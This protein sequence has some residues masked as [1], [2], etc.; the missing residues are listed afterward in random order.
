MSPSGIVCRQD[1][2]HVQPLQRLFVMFPAGTAGSGLLV[3]RL[4]AAGM[5]V[6]D[7]MPQTT[8]VPS[9]WGAA[10]VLLVAAVLAAGALT[11]VGC[12]ASGL[13]QIVTVSSGT[14]QHLVDLALSLGVTL[15][16]FLVGPGA[17]SVDGH[18]YG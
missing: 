5:L 15:A 3:L 13:V 4:C 16:L 18:V 14:D 17:F 6:R 8:A 1:S 11:P 10:V 12:I 2:G 9:S 7:T